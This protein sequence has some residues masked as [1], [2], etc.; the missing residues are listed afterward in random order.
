MS[1]KPNHYM[2]NEEIDI[3]YDEDDKTYIVSNEKG[4]YMYSKSEPVLGCRRNESSVCYH[5][6]QFDI[7]KCWKKDK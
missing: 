5:D 2:V 3:E 4:E 6:D 1:D 7:I